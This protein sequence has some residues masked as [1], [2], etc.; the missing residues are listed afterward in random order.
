MTRPVDY[1]VDSEAFLLF[2][3][4]AL[5]EMGSVYRIEELVPSR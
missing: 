3:P 5:N 2:W 1:V 4:A